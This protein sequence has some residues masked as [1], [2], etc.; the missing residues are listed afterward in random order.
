MVIFGNFCNPLGY[1]GTES[2]LTTYRNT[3][4]NTL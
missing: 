2:V 4:N 1:G 3:P